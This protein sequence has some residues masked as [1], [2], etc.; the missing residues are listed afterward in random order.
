LKTCIFLAPFTDF[1]FLFFAE[2]K[3]GGFCC[4]TKLLRNDL[5]QKDAE[6]SEDNEAQVE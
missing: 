5:V 1:S 3:N 2:P 4:H 6:K